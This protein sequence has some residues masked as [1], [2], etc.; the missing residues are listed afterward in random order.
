M[1]AALGHGDRFI[2][3]G[4]DFVHLAQS[5][6]G[7]HEGELVFPGFFHDVLPAQRQT[8]PVHRHRGQLISRHFE[9]GAGVDGTA[10]IVADGKNHPG[11]HGAQL[12]LLHGQAVPFVYSGQFRKFF[13]AAAHDVEGSGSA[14]NVDLAAIRGDGDHIVGQPANDLPE[15]AGGQDNGSGLGYTGLHLGD[16]SRLQIVAADA[17]AGGQSFHQNALQ[18]LDGTL[19]G[20][21]PA[22]SGDGVLQ[23]CFFTGKFHGRF[24]FPPPRL[25]REVFINRSA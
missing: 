7:Y 4:T 15:Q 6:A 24:P 2:A 11:N 13:R 16:N 25:D 9:E 23:Q 12:S 8:V 21:D 17:Q 3:V 14:H 19:G 22:G 10:L 20:H 5:G 1:P 18:G